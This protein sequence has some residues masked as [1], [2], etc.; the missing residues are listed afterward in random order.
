VKLMVWDRNGSVESIKQIIKNL[1][2]AKVDE[3]TG[4]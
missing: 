3:K 4:M 1:N 2:E